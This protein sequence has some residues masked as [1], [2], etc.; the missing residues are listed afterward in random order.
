MEEG[1]SPGAVAEA[2]E[3]SE[4][5]GEGELCPKALVVVGPAVFWLVSGGL[6]QKSGTVWFQQTPV[7]PFSLRS[8]EVEM[9]ERW[10]TCQVRGAVSLMLSEAVQCCPGFPRCF[11]ESRPWVLNLGAVL[12]CHSLTVVSS[13]G[14]A[15]LRLC[16]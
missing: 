13:V 6:Q 5:E 8:T 7:V 10:I 9:L 15:L 3:L 14:R 16:P 11:P 12:I 1:V 4:E 2:E